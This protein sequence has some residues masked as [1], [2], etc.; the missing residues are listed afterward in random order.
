MN[1]GALG[2]RDSTLTDKVGTIRGR[3]PISAS[4]LCVQALKGWRGFC[5]LATSVGTPAVV[6]LGR[7]PRYDCLQPGHLRRDT[8]SCQFGKEP[9][10]WPSAACSTSPSQEEDV[11]KRDRASLD[12]PALHPG[13]PHVY[14]TSWKL[15]SGHI[16]SCVGQWE[17]MLPPNAL[18]LLSIYRTL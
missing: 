17:S 16:L 11:F 1:Q 12:E 3:L 6:S 10:S 5:S 9:M 4:G 7:N 13:L 15:P 18:G 2:S 8:S 14:P